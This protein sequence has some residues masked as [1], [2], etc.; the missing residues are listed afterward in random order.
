MSLVRMLEKEAEG[1]VHGFLKA[2]NV[3]F[4]SVDNGELLMT[5]D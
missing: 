1:R 2:R 3:D 4:I 5:S